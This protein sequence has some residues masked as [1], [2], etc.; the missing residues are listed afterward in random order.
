[1]IEMTIKSDKMTTKSEK[2]LNLCPE[3]GGRIIPIHESGD[4]ICGQCGLVIDEKSI[5]FAHSGRRAFTSHEK[6]QRE[7][8]GSPISK[9]LPD[10]GLTTVI[11][12]RD[13][14]SP[15]LKRAAKWNTR[16]S[17][18]KRNLLI[19]IT[20]LKRISSNLNLPDH[21]KEEAMLLYKKAF[22]K[23]LLRGRSINGMVAAC[24]YYA[25][26]V[27]RIPRTF[28]E[29]IEEA[30]VDAKEVRRCY[31]V[32]IRE[33]KLK[34]PNS[35]PIA[36]IP[37]FI[38]DMGL[39][40]EIEVLTVELLNAYKSNVST[41]GKDPKGIVAGAIYLACKINGQL[42]TQSEVAK[43]IGVTEVTLRSRYKEFL[44]NN[45]K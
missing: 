31:T 13:I 40:N 6:K 15:D 38:T 10:I 33:F 27:K 3:C 44:K 34:V 29:I 19:A 12:K 37:K 39:N 32:I 17:W 43:T 28:Q 2:I 42:V 36:L 23:K 45:N 20:E 11:D 25:C 8:T 26:K 21:V 9:L 14:T 1:M 22:K 5:D 35:D 24:L 41:S 30:S 16:I 18:E 4:V 7:T